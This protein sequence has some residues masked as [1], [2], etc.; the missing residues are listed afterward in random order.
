WRWRPRRSCPPQGAVFRTMWRA[1][2][3]LFPGLASLREGLLEQLPDVADAFLDGCFQEQLPLL[4]GGER[5][6]ALHAAAA[7]RGPPRHVAKRSVGPPLESSAFAGGIAL[8]V[9]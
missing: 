6:G 8:L 1:A 9:D 7:E 3:G 2:S 4:R 5:G